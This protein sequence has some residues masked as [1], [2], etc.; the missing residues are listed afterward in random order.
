MSLEW[1]GG[2]VWGEGGWVWMRGAR[3]VEGCGVAGACAT[4][5]GWCGLHWELVNNAG[6]SPTGSNAQTD[7]KPASDEVMRALGVRAR[8][9]MGSLQRP[10]TR[11]PGSARECGLALRSDPLASAVC[12]SWLQVWFGEQCHGASRKTPYQSLE[13][14]QKGLQTMA[15]LRSWVSDP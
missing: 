2:P 11:A 4:V 1:S 7:S 13:T 3:G 12:G 8:K 9:C 15:K 5:A 10:G 6:L 14:P